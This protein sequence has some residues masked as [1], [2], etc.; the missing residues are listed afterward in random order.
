MT[1]VTGPD[2]AAGDTSAR[3]G[4]A[5]LRRAMI[6]G[7]LRT[8]GV[9]DPHVLEAIN[10]LP[11]EDFVPP[12]RRAV[13]YSDRSQPL[14]QGRVLAPVIT[15]G[16]MLVEA[17][18]T[19]ADRALLIGGGTGYLAALLAPMVG[20]LTVIESDEGLAAAAPVQSGDW[21]IGSLEAGAAADAPFSL[22]VIDG[23]IEQ[24]PD[25]IAA[26]LGE[27]GR[28]VTGLV[29]RGVNRLAVGRKANGRVGFVTVGEADFAV[30]EPFREPRRW[31]F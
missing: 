6:D 24:V 4:S 26:Q 9:N 2:A 8:S 16:Q 19:P 11:R 30:L 22:I 21:T 17:R 3:D 25:A 15:H 14:G 29:E 20:S 13:A 28:I 12:A 7:Q 23:A 31:S 5:T 1:V 27:N 18:P 10:A